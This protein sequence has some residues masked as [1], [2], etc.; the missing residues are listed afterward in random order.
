[1]SDYYSVMAFLNDIRSKSSLNISISDWQWYLCFCQKM[2]SSTTISIPP[3]GHK[4]VSSSMRFSNGVRVS[5]CVLGV[6]LD[7]SGP[8]FS[9][10]SFTMLHTSSRAS[11]MFWAYSV[12]LRNS[13]IDNPYK[14]NEV[15]VTLR[16]EVYVFSF[17]QNQS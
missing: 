17:A 14:D 7:R 2:Q 16:M 4:I 12:H 10:C 11:T 5:Q 3:W 6:L 15:S 1:M 8:A 13:P 9:R